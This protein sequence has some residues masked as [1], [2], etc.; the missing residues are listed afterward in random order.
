[1]GLDFQQKE[2]SGPVDLKIYIR[3]NIN[4]ALS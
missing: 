4:N 3:K 2:N 1:M